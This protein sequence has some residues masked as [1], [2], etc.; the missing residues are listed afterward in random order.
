MVKKSSKEITYFVLIFIMFY[1]GV[2]M[3]NYW[4]NHAKINPDVSILI[5]GVVVCL[6]LASIYYFSGLSSNSENFW[7]ITP[8]ALCKGGPYMWQ[9]DSETAKMCRDMANTPE[10]RC[11][12]SSYNCPSGYNGT[13]RIQFEYTP[14]S[15]DTWENERCQ[16]DK[17]APCND[18]GLCAF[19]KQPYQGSYPSCS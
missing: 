14:L 18:V 9:G 13:P 3:S 10:G 1:L 16:D 2:K 7:D 17:K 6:I 4:I 12:I 15:G 8:A 11:A 5:I 19:E